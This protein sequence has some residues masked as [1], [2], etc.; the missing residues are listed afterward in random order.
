[1][2][3]NG[4]GYS[5]IIRK[6]KEESEICLKRDLLDYQKITRKYF[7]RTID[8]S[9]ESELDVDSSL[10][11]SKHNYVGNCYSFPQDPVTLEPLLGYYFAIPTEACREFTISQIREKIDQILAKQEEGSIR[12]SDLTGEPFGITA[13]LQGSTD[14]LLRSVAELIVSKLL[15]WA[16]EKAKRE[17]LTLED[18]FFGRKECR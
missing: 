6:L 1:M 15:L 16:G 8:I 18:E 2:P 7:G 13:K 14:T 11:W 5:L 3:S 12:L 4:D 10:S 9:E 17:N